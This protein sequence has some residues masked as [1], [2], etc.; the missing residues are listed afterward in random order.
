MVILL[1]WFACDF[2]SIIYGFIANCRKC[3]ENEP[4]VIE[5]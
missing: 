4:V 3:I 5:D 2:R 1:E